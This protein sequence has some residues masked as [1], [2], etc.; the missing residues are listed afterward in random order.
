MS[1]IQVLLNAVGS[2]D[3]ILRVSQPLFV[4]LHDE[5]LLQDLIHASET[6][7]LLS[8]VPTIETIIPVVLQPLEDQQLQHLS[9]PADPTQEVSN[10]VDRIHL[11]HDV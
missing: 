7:D 2:K 9:I 3:R 4:R 5:L 6:Q 1:P 8:A 11:I 10:A